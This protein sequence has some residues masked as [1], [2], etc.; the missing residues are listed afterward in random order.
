LILRSIYQGFL[1]D[2]LQKNQYHKQP[3]TIDEIIDH[4]YEIYVE[5]GSTNYLVEYDMFRGR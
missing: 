1:F 4:N 3:K 5:E 2:I